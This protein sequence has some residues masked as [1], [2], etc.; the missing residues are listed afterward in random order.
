M[1]RCI[2]CALKFTCG[3]ANKNNI[4]EKHIKRKGTYTRLEEKDRDYYKFVK[5]EAKDEKE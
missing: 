3:K 5:M 1:K 2:D 4:C